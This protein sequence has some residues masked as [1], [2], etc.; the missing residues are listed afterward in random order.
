M[1]E[2]TSV[3]RDRFGFSQFRP[4]Q[5][6]IIESSLQ[7]EDV[8]AILPTGGGKSLCYQ[9]P[10]IMRDGIT[11]I[12]SPLIALMK[13]QVDGLEENGVPAGYLNSAQSEDEAR[14]VWRALHNGA[15]KILYVSP[16]RLLLDGMLQRL[17]DAGLCFVAVDEAHCISAWGHDFR[18]EFR[19]LKVVREKYPH[20]P[21]MALTATATEQ[22]RADIAGLLGLRDPKLYIGSFNRPNLSY[23]VVPRRNGAQQ[24][25]EILADH[26]GESAI[27]YCLARATTEDLAAKLQDRGISAQAYH[28]G[29]DAATRER[30]QEQFSKDKVQVMVATI[31]FGMGIDKPDVRC[32]I[33]YNLPKNIESYYQETGRAGRDGLPSECVLL[34]EPGDGA[35]IRSFIEQSSD[36]QE[37]RVAR[38]QLAALTRFVESAGCRRVE[39]LQYFGESY[40]DESGG[41]RSSC[42]GCDNCLSP[43][44]E[45]DMTDLA[46]RILSCAVRIKQASGFSVGLHH[47]VDVVSGARTEKIRQW[48][49]DSL[50]TYGIAADYS[51]SDLL[52]YARELVR[53]EAIR[54]VE[55]RYGVV[56]V[57][58]RGIELLKSR[59]PISL[60]VPMVNARLSAEKKR[61]Q[62]ESLGD[63]AYDTELFDRLRSWRREAA[64]K[65]RVPAYV[66]FS[67]ATLRELAQE[68]PQSLEALL[69]VSGIGEKKRTLYG[70]ELLALLRG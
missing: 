29:L 3:L 36:P 40:C 15:I 55:D 2:L 58:A 43:R 62:R 24:V 70:D 46:Q 50:S 19:G 26:K 30:R 42:G 18:P 39:L 25:E 41:R 47:L 32:V 37:Q 66:I 12:V 67:D 65:K 9:I 21:L 61:R 13:D 8:L 33:H 5:R 51:R 23:R 34:Y 52:Y 6:E 63:V 17:H 54:I 10:A 16:E 4:H 14:K 45:S 35:K 20:L 57:T 1:D 48:K 64:E 60:R 68:R 7:G 53:I 69:N 49:H 11:V 27:V 28:A 31:A 44:Q 59:S 38:Q 56:E 22:V